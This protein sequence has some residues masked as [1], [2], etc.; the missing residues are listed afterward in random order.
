MGGWLAHL[1]SAGMTFLFYAPL[2][3]AAA[4]GLAFP[5]KETLAKK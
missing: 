4:A 2:L 3:L 1:F 5:A